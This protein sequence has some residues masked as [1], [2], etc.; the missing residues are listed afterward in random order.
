MD[1]LRRDKLFSPNTDCAWSKS[2]A[3]VPIID[4]S[5]IDSLNNLYRIYYTTRNVKG[6]SLPSYIHVKLRNKVTVEYIHNKP[7]C[8]LGKIGYFDDSGVM[9]F[10]YRMECKF[11][12]FLQISDWP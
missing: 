9:A 3:Q 11:K 6:E 10:L 7:I 2:H 12:N 8:M 4:K 1:W 5:P